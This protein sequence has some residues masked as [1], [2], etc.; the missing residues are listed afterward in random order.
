MKDQKRLTAHSR[1]LCSQK[2][3]K[4]SIGL[5]ILVAPVRKLLHKTPYHIEY[6]ARFVFSVFL[7]KMHRGVSPRILYRREGCIGIVKKFSIAGQ[8]VAISRP[9]SV[10]PAL[11]IR[12]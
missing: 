4:L 5:P 2:H 3:R 6:M 8:A 1:K 11:E 9:L 12:Q 7:I 10:N